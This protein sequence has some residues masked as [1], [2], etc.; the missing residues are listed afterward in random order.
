MP[1]TN[2]PQPSKKPETP[3]RNPSR[4]AVLGTSCSGKTT[5]ARTLASM[6]DTRHIE[7]DALHW[8]PNWVQMP[9]EE[10]REQA[11]EAVKPDRWVMD[12]NY[13]KIRDIVWGRATALIWLNYPLPF[14]FWRGLCRCT[15]RILT[16]E[17]IF[18]GNRESV[19]LTFLSRDSLLLWILQTHGRRR[20]EYPELFKAPHF[21]HLEVVELN[22]QSET[23]ALVAAFRAG[24]V[25]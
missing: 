13:G 1:S 18:N 14:V 17:E 2:L 24:L 16:R 19:R 22:S 15:K 21:S 12:G 11:E 5:L 25:E 8:Q 4:I 9:I 23:D 6:L 7:L 10:F 20:K 3:F